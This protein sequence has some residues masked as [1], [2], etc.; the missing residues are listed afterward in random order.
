M[1]FVSINAA[2]ESL[3]LAFVAVNGLR[4]TLFVA[5]VYA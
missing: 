2:P 5:V 4:V 1:L 3:Q